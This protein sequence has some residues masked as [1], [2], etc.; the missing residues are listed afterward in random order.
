MNAKKIAL[1]AAIG[2]ALIMILVIAVILLTPRKPVIAFY[3]VPDAIQAAIV[4][5]ADDP[6]YGKK[7]I[8]ILMLDPA[9]DL[10]AQKKTVK[11]ANVL[12]TMDGRAAAE[13]CATAAAPDEK[14][15]AQM[16]SAIR[17]IGRTDTS[18]YGLP[19]LLDHFEFAYGSAFAR[20]Y[21]LTPASPLDDFLGAAKKSLR[22]GLWPIACAGANDADIVMTV[23][24]LAEARFG[25]ESRN[26]IVRELRADKDFRAVLASTKLKAVL[27]E[28]VAWRKAGIIHPEWFRMTSDDVI[29]FMDNGYSEIIFMSLSTHRTIPQR[30]IARYEGIP[31]PSAT[32][33]TARTLTVPALI[34]VVVSKKGQNAEANAF[35]ARLA[36]VEGQ[37][38][39]AALSGLAP[40]NSTAE[41]RDIQA[42]DVRLWAAASD[43][44]VP[45]IAT[46]SFVENEKKAQFAKD[47]RAYIE[48]DG[49]G[50]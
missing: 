19:L 50:Y 12:F 32:K 27:D 6:A 49:F 43:R 8:G 37:G 5:L 4:K 16:P 15:L 30:T 10:S 28:L 17:R 36:S 35:L 14:I 42:S 25:T 11:K 2:A 29:A 46:D 34:G 21:R 24:A 33:Q 7:T 13:A 26:A 22:E 48:T 47:I 45:D 44:P 23:S 1:P 18:A 41:A 38:T 39:L 31:F 9:K 3:R 40:V 20:Q